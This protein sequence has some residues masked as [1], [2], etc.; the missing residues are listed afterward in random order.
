MTPEQDYLLNMFRSPATSVLARRAARIG[1][2]LVLVAGMLLVAHGS[3]PRDTLVVTWPVA[4]SVFLVIR[5]GVWLVAPA[6]R[7]D[8][9]LR[10]SLVVPAIG[11]ALALPLTIH[12][13]W[14]VIAG[15]NFDR[16]AQLSVPAAGAAHVAFAVLFAFRAAELART[17]DPH[18]SISTIY[19]LTVLASTIP[20]GVFIL[21]ELRR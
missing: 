8:A 1:L 14:F 7:G 11:L 19:L 13:L 3:A 21:P 10:A 17:G 20:F 2:G 12:L 5:A 15:A 16:W 18:L 6:P 9:L 4:G